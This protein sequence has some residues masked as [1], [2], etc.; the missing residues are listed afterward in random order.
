MKKKGEGE[1]GEQS[2][3]LSVSSC[4]AQIKAPRALCRHLHFPFFDQNFCL[5]TP[6]WVVARET[7]LW[8]GVRSA[9]QSW[10]AVSE[11]LNHL[12][13]SLSLIVKERTGA[14]GLSFQSRCFFSLYPVFLIIIAVYPFPWLASISLNYTFIE[15]KLFQKLRNIM[16]ELN[17]SLSLPS[18]HLLYNG[19]YTELDM[20]WTDAHAEDFQVLVYDSELV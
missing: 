8:K 9:N 2:H 3:L 7:G 10:L 20:N 4:I 16:C 12:S 18:W 15:A 11:M 13:N 19:D 17:V 5:A 1:R 14:H 6:S